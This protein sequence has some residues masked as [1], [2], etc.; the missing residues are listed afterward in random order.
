MVL[1]MMAMWITALLLWSVTPSRIMM[2][3]TFLPTPSLFS[4]SCMAVGRVIRAQ[5]GGQA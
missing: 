3:L 5:P 1:R 2:L 4:T